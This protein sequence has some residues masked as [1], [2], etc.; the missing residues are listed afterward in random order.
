MATVH[1][2]EYARFVMTCREKGIEPRDYM[3][4]RSD[5]LL[6]Y[7]SYTKDDIANIILFIEDI[8]H[9]VEMLS[10]DENYYELTEESKNHVELML[11]TPKRINFVIKW[12]RN[13]FHQWT[14]N[15]DMR[16]GM[17]LLES[18]RYLKELYKFVETCDSILMESITGNTRKK[19]LALHPSSAMQRMTI[20]QL[21]TLVSPV[22]VSPDSAE[23]VAL[24][25][26]MADALIAETK[27]HHHRRR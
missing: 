15:F 4:K 18:I 21:R 12:M 27:S 2:S 22:H 25:K 14:L 26:Y 3:T 16:R 7:D 23:Y 6:V 9:I 19:K 13:M 1:E 20:E 24:D 8:D 10:I 11:E 5:C 17:A